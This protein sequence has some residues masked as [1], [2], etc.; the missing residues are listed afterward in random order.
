MD[1]GQMRPS[2]PVSGSDKPNKINYGNYNRY[3]TVSMN[4]HV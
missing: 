1:V 4:D 2:P 3:F